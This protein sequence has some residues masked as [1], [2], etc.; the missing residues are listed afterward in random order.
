M[1]AENSEFAGQPGAPQ[2]AYVPAWH[3]QPL[4]H[5]QVAVLTVAFAAAIT[6]AGASATGNGGVSVTTKSAAC[7]ETAKKPRV[8]ESK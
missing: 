7:A 3:G 2:L 1:D 5:G 6:G 4:P 8:R